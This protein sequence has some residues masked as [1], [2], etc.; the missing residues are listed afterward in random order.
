MQLQSADVIRKCFNSQHYW[1]PFVIM[2]VCVF[3][4]SFFSLSLYIY[5]EDYC[6]VGSTFHLKGAL[7]VAMDLDT[8]LLQLFDNV[9]P[10]FFMS[11][12]ALYFIQ[13]NT[14]WG[15][16]TLHSCPLWTSSRAI[17]GRGDG[18]SAT[19]PPS[20]PSRSVCTST[21]RTKLLMP[22]IPTIVHLV[23]PTPPRCA[24]WDS[25]TWTCPMCWC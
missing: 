17:R 9:M 11:H 6:G 10:P 7:L 24:R 18:A 22:L 20:S 16:N 23:L 2:I 5:I 14:G 4:F 1:H 3:S 21:A 19:T 13:T 8:R 25:A 15:E 12:F